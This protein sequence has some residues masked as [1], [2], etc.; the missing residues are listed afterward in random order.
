ML[1]KRETPI[2]GQY[3]RCVD[4]LAIEFLEQFGTTLARRCILAFS[5][6]VVVRIDSLR[7]IQKFMNDQKSAFRNTES[8]GRMWWETHENDPHGLMILTILLL[9]KNHTRPS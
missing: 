8:V 2:R 4:S 3:D 7:E 5:N 6:S 1:G 9:N